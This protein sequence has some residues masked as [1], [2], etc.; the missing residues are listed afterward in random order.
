MLTDRRAPAAQARAPVLA[1]LTDGSTATFPAL[2]LLPPVLAKA[3]AAAVF[4][5]AAVPA[6]D[7]YV[8]DAALPARVPLPPVVTNAPAATLDAHCAHTIVRADALP[9]AIAA[10]ATLPPVG[11]T[12]RPGRERLP[13]LQAQ[14]RTARSGRE[15]HEDQRGEKPRGAPSTVA[16]RAG[17]ACALASPEMRRHQRGMP[18]R[19]CTL[20]LPLERNIFILP[21]SRTWCSL[22]LFGG[23]DSRAWIRTTTVRSQD[24]SV[25]A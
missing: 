19:A 3:S 25:V 22:P 24:G 12:L 2:S 17:L 18:S 11:A 21:Q 10:L 4:A 14:S 13:T 8:A 5:D 6:V 15:P 23:L 7:A 9:A 1:V 20:R 16:S